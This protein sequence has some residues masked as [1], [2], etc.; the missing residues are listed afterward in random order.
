MKKNK[1]VGRIKL[2]KSQKIFP[3]SVNAFNVPLGPQGNIIHCCHILTFGGISFSV[4]SSYSNSA[5]DGNSAASTMCINPSGPC[6][7]CNSCNVFPQSC[8]WL[9]AR[10]LENLSVPFPFLPLI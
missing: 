4:L 2:I 3:I 7:A 9:G 6:S 10:G 5:D 1:E 8:C